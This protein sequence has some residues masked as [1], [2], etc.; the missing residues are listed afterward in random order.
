MTSTGIKFAN[1]SQG[2]GPVTKTGD[3]VLVDVVGRLPGGKV[4]ID[5]RELGAPIAFQ[6]GTSNKLVPEGLSQI[7]EGMEA[8]SVRLAVLPAE[9][10]YQDQPVKMPGGVTVPPNTK[11]YYEV[12]LL[13]CETFTLGL[14]CCTEGAFNRNGGSCVKSKDAADK[15][16]AEQAAAAAQ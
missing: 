14:A 3:L 12:E 9:L 4:F 13:R 15:L 16:A 11:L 6:V 2:S 10:G 1:V 7:V 8:G 5:T